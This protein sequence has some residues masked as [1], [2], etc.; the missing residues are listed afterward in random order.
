MS[1]INETGHAK[2]VANFRKTRYQHL[3]PGRSLQPLQREPQTTG[4]QHPAGQCKSAIVACNTAEAAA[5]NAV[6]SR[7]LVFEPLSK[8]TTRVHNALKVSGAPKALVE[9]AIS[10]IRKLQSPLGQLQNDR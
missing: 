3:R 6:K 10:I 1:T 4:S 9:S 8:L 7:E 5:K 2:N